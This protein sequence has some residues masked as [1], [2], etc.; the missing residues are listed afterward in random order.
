MGINAMN[1]LTK[2]FCLFPVL[3]GISGCASNKEFTTPIEAIA[4]PPI[5]DTTTPYSDLLVCIGEAA[6]AK[7]EH[8]ITLAV[9]TIPDKTGKFNYNEEGYKVTQGAEDMVVS[10]IA[11]T[12]AYTLVERNAL[13]IS[14]M[15]MQYANQFL[16]SD[17]NPHK[18][19]VDK[20]GRLAR[21][22][23]SGMVIGSDYVVAGSISE[24]N[25]NI[26]SGGFSVTV[27]G[28]GGGWRVFWMDIG[29]DLRVID[30]TT[31][32]IVIAL[33]Q[34]KQVWGYENKA[35]VVHFFGNT[36]V[37]GVA[38]TIRQEPI[39][40]AVRSIIEDSIVDITRQLYG[41]PKNVCGDV[42]TVASKEPTT[43]AAE[44]AKATPAAATTATKNEHPEEVSYLSASES[45]EAYIAEAEAAR[46]SQAKAAY[47]AEP[48]NGQSTDP[49]PET[50]AA[51][52]GQS[53]GQERVSLNENAQLSRPTAAVQPMSEHIS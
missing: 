29:M 28:I 13:G 17:S 35:G 40:I 52:S 16:L 18:N 30:T 46:F 44:P 45:N 53:A 41:I 2:I 10:A 50:E 37:E 48:L 49:T 20:E 14:Q 47:L 51:Q 26:G 23:H 24:I 9:N 42:G 21:A 31:T 43:T 7:G 1:Q 15:E 38:G 25:F 39:Q 22:L 33:P 12:N 8:R 32:E 34:R 11:K 4:G 19:F 27:D 6:N 5:Q 36:F 3:L